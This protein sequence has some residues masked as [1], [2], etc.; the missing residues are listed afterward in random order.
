MGTAVIAGV[1]AAKRDGLARKHQ[2]SRTTSGLI[3]K[4][5]MASGGLAI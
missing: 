3:L 2:H 5:E 1:K 4:S